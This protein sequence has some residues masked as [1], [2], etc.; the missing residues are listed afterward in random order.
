LAVPRRAL[1]AI[2]FTFGVASAGW[3]A[4]PGP[5]LGWDPSTFSSASEQ[6][7]VALTNQSRAAAG[8][9]T[10]RVDT[11]LRAYARARSKDMIVRDYFSHEIPP[12]GKSVF[13]QLQDGG[14]CFSLAGENIGWNT[15]PDDQ[16]TAAIHQMFLDSPGHRENIMGRRWEVV[17]VGAYKGPSGKKMWTVLFADRCGSTA[18]KPAPRTTPKPVA[19]AKPA[20]TPRPAAPTPRPA[21]PTPRPAPRPRPTPVPTAAPVLVADVQ[22][23]VDLTSPSSSGRPATDDA[24]PVEVV[25]DGFR[26]VDPPPDQGLVASIVGEVA[27]SYFG[28]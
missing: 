20:A 4:V 9:R 17:A 19:K 3:L 24:R 23:N 22:R 26:V 15:Y 1:L 10:L 2:A 28:S 16:A 13:D 14:Y 21:A 6:E 8:L 12:S 25:A 11:T 7:L 18:A 27:G 5:A